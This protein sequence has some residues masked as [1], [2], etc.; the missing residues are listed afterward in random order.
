MGFYRQW[1]AELE[2]AKRKKR[3]PSFVWAIFRTFSREYFLL[4]LYQILNEFVLR[5]ISKH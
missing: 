1:F 5:Y 2:R 3:R 4:G